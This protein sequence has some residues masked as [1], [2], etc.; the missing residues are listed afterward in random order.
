MRRLYTFSACP[1]LEYG[2]VVWSLLY[3]KDAESI[4]NTQRRTTKL[5]HGF[6]EVP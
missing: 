1:L 2:N 3:K 6:K 5:V 4:E